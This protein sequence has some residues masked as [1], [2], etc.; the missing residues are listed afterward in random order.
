MA[1]EFFQQ[2]TAASGFPRVFF[3]LAQIVVRVAHVAFNVSMSLIIVS[4][5]EEIRFSF[6]ALLEGGGKIYIE[7]P[8]HVPHKTVTALS[9]G[10]GNGL[11]EQFDCF[12]DHLELGKRIPGIPAHKGFTI[13]H[14]FLRGALFGILHGRG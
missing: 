2:P 5:I 7:V 13:L 6:P 10:Q 12:L 11:V 1:T 9:R 14:H 3:N 4:Y 8:T